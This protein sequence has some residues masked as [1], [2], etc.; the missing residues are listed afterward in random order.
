[1]FTPDGESVLASVAAAQERLLALG[2][3]FEMVD[4]EVFGRP[5]KAFK[6]RL[7]CLR[8]ILVSSTRHGD[9]LA[10]VF[11]DGRQF[12]YRDFERAVA[13]VATDLREQYGVGVG[14]RVAIAAANSVEW[15]LTFWGCAVLGAVTVAMNAW[16]TPA[17]MAN[18]IELTDPKL[19]VADERRR[20]RIAPSV[21]IKVLAIESDIVYRTDHELALPDG[22]VGEFDDALMLFTSGTTGRPKAAVLT[23]GNLIGFDKLQSIIGARAML[24][25]GREPAAGPPPTRLAVF[26]LFHISGVVS[27]AIATLHSGATTVWTTGRFDPSTVIELTREHGIS[28][29]TGASTHIVRILDHPDL[30]EFDGSTLLQIGVGGSASSPEIIRRTE[31]RFPHLVGT[32]SSGYGSTETGG[33]VSWT[34]AGLLKE[35]PDTVGPAL[36]G[37]EIR[38][39]DEDRRDVDDGGEG[40]IWVRSALVMREYWGHP[41]ANADS[42]LDGGWFKLGDVGRLVNGVL[43]IASRRRDLIL[44]GGENIY[45]FE[46]ENRLE[47]H[48][49]VLEAAVYGVDDRLHGQI[50]RA[51]V[52]LRRGFDTDM[53]Q[54]RAHCAEVLS[55]YKVPEHIDIRD[56]PLPRNATGKVLKHVL[57]GEAEN[58]F[59]DN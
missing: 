39:L 40:D 15:L 32:F 51:A 9:H 30:I 10:A 19:I 11:G 59:I 7:F 49:A 33:L 13:A 27:T 50:V 45:P 43:F 3:Q 20:E 57:R 36:P 55:A 24:M 18:A 16:W 42:F 21:G 35:A 1:V 5:T 53:E 23:H 28:M 31:E 17:E 54:L 38:I 6:N 58:T 56:E 26:P 4:I 25:S 47:E 12:S 34:P 14:D 29:W 52:V 8:E 22:Q 41:E 37:V 2:S 48:P 46:I 44:R